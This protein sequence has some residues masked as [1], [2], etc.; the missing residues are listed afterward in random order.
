MPKANLR[1]PSKK[2]AKAALLPF[3]RVKATKL[4]AQDITFKIVGKTPL[5]TDRMSEE[6]IDK[7]ERKQTGNNEAVPLSPRN[8]EEE[9]ERSKYLIEANGRKVDAFPVGA[10]IDAMAEVSVYADGLDKK[11][12]KAAVSA[13]EEFAILHFKQVKMNR[14]MGR[15]SGIGGS[16]TPRYRAEYFDW[17]LELKLT[18]IPLLLSKDQVATL[19]YN[20]GTAIG[21]GNWTRQHSG[22]RG[23]FEVK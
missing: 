12:V 21:V 7:V 9:Y 23:A 14:A 10:F 15:N 19:I 20:A 2:A 18:I 22:F 5:L 1:K 11:R 4:E 6:A 3:Q 16:R 13:R 17:W 8:P